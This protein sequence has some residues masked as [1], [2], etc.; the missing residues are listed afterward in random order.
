MDWPLNDFI[1]D[2][3]DVEAIMDEDEYQ[4]DMRTTL[5]MNLNIGRLLPLK[6]LFYAI[7]S[8]T[9]L[10][11]GRRLNLDKMTF[12][13]IEGQLYHESCSSLLRDPMKIERSL[14]LL[15]SLGLLRAERDESTHASVYA[16]QA[17]HY[18]SFLRTRN[19]FGDHI[20]QALKEF[21]QDTKELVPRQVWTLNDDDL[22][23]LVDPEYRVKI[24]FGLSGSG[25]DYLASL[26]AQ[27]RKGAVRSRFDITD[28]NATGLENAL[29]D[30]SVEMLVVVDKSGYLPWQTIAGILASA[31][32][33]ATP[34]IRWIAGPK[35]SQEYV[36]TEESLDFAGDVVGMGSLTSAELEVWGAREI[37]QELY[38]SPGPNL[39]IADSDRERVI[40]VLGGLLPVMERWREFLGNTPP[41][42]IEVRHAE[43]FRLGI[44]K[45]QNVTKMVH[46]FADG[47]PTPLRSG[48]MLL[49]QICN[50][51]FEG[52]DGYIY[53][54]NDLIKLHDHLN[55]LEGHHA[56]LI[57]DWVDVARW[58]QLLEV[59]KIL[60]FIESNEDKSCPLYRIPTGTALGALV[61]NPNF[62]FEHDAN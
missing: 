26:L 58:I 28:S 60:G 31:R 35:T 51:Q 19:N 15:C 50:T 37:G 7:V 2:I 56:D 53:E 44:V 24:I 1:I 8:P 3:E 29:K 59:C 18:A 48:I 34:S 12:A 20:D 11:R 40:E 25:R 5:E 27:G 32:K 62:C 39:F 55:S 36:E 22:H 42:P 43:E 17:R 46:K 6:L 45:N 54:D 57:A 14:D 41:D 21:Q 13:D 61:L 4:R 30:N 47:I 16:V 49:Y 9:G 52:M 38:G 10:D 23:V 33:N